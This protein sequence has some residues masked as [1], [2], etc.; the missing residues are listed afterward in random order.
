MIKTITLKDKETLNKIKK[1]SSGD[2]DDAI[3]ATK[4]IIDEVKKNG[5]KA[6]I[7]FSKKFDNY[8]LKNIQVSK[9]EIKQAYKKVDK[10]TI[11]ALKKSIT[12]IKT[13]AKLQM[14]KEW[15]KTISKGVE[16]GQIIRPLESVGCYI[17]GGLYALPSSVLMTVIPAK[18]AGVKNIVVCTPPRKNNELVIVAADLAGANKIFK[19][20]GAQAIAA[21]A[22]GTKSIPKV[23]KIVGPGNIY[24]TAA[25]K[26]LYGEVG[27]DFLAGPSE[28]LIYAEKGN[29]NFIA[30]DMLAQAEHDRYASAILVTPNKTLAKKVAKAIDEQLTQLPTQIIARQSLRNYS[31]II[32]VKN[33]KEAINFIN[34]FAPEHLELFQESILKD[35]KNAGAIFLG[36]NTCEAAGDYATGPSH[37]LPTGQ[38]S[39][40]R[41]GLSVYDFIKMPSIQKISKEGIK[42]LKPTIKTIAKEEGLLA[43]KKSAELR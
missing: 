7:N 1:R 32:L 37:V 30:A 5:D 28:I 14:P 19:V 23:N 21:L 38:A 9:K 4:V 16:V 41:S 31:A 3:K 40:Y 11:N 39:K 12:N 34:D 22:Y 29:E 17:P 13:Y 2:I 43:H 15:K 25:K 10:E 6:L 33:K 27:L 26:I 36:E 8:K 35:I 20:G 24:V 18:V 42:S